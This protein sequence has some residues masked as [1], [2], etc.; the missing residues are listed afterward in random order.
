MKKR[1]IVFSI[2]ISLC[3]PSMSSFARIPQDKIGDFLS[4]AE[5]YS[6]SS[7]KDKYITR[8]EFAMMAAKITGIE[9]A[10]ALYDFTPFDDV[11][12]DKEEFGAVALLYD[13]GII[14]GDGHGEVFRTDDFITDF[15]DLNFMLI[16]RGIMV[17]LLQRDFLRG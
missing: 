13:M 9:N 10:E 17:L 4:H 6:L 12:K 14:K 16:L 15:W 3:L 2:I 8:G 5:L 11:T 1:L 7:S